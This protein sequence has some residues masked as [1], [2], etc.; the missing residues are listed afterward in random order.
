MILIGNVM[1]FS[2]SVWKFK[3]CSQDII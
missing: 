1:Q 3:E 2:V